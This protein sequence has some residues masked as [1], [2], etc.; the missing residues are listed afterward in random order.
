MT[1]RAVTAVLALAC[2]ALACTPVLDWRDVRP[3]GAGLVALFPCKPAGHA[4][5]I[6]LADTPVEMTIYA[7]SAGG[8]TYAVGFTD[9]GHAERVER[10]LSALAE[11][12][13][14]NIGSALAADATP[15]SVPGMTPNPRAQLFS[16]VGRL[17]DG[18][19]VQERVAVF[20]R[21]TRV[22][23]ATIVGAQLRADA[24]DAFFGA[25]RLQG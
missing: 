21:G 14:R 5:R 17:A 19:P 16:L 7:C 13:A 6:V 25:L 24:V 2:G 12:A 22:Y 11:A 18:R 4:R 23:Q 20:S 15:M 9:L 3:P 1:L 10:G 8:A